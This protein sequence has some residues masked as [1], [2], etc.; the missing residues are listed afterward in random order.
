MVRVIVEV[1]ED[2]TAE[3]GDSPR[4]T[5]KVYKETSADSREAEIAAADGLL[6]EVQNTLRIASDNSKPLKWED[7]EIE[8][9][10]KKPEIEQGT[11][12]F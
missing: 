1:K 10:N 9:D 6:A 2:K 5:C 3:D 12:G 11:F 8:V 7:R 4:V